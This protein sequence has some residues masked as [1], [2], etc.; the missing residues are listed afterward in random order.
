[1][2][3]V[4]HSAKHRIPKPKS[5]EILDHLLTQ[6]MVD[7]ED[8]GFFPVRCQFLMQVDGGFE[9]PPKGLFDLENGKGLFE[10]RSCSMEEDI[11]TYDNLRFTI[12]RVAILP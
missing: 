1:M 7:A 6:I 2:I 11:Q 8:L 4:P 3:T 9:I 5:H 12:F 10:P